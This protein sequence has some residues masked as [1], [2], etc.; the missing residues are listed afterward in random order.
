M[1]E[2]YLGRYLDSKWIVHH[3]N[4]I[5]DDNRIEN[6]MCFISISAHRRFHGNPNNVKPEEII[7]DGRKL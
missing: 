5:R 7:F 2:K 4:N 3:I 1:V 6:L